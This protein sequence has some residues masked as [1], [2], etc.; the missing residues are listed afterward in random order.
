MR[1][2]YRHVFVAALCALCP[3][4]AWAETTEAQSSAGDTGS[5][6]ITDADQPQGSPSDQ[7]MVAGAVQ[8]PVC[9]GSGSCD[10]RSGSERSWSPSY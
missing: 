8:G 5:Y 2:A 9:D 4:V 1:I 10:G 6:F 3:A 7:P